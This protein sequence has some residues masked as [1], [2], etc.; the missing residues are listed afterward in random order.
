MNLMFDGGAF[1]C[2]FRPDHWAF[3]TKMSQFFPLS[4]TLKVKAV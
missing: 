1:S 3:I 2:H 4:K